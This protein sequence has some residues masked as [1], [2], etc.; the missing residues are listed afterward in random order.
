MPCEMH[1]HRAK[2]MLFECN[3]QRMSC[4]TPRNQR[5]PYLD[6]S[7]IVSGAWTSPAGQQLRQQLLTTAN[8]P[9]GQLIGLPPGLSLTTSSPSPVAARATGP[10]YAEGKIRWYTWLVI[11][12]VLLL[13]LILVAITVY[14]MR[15]FNRG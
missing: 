15:G 8:S 4:E 1:S 11:S 5:E 13:V 6:I 3:K 10:R 7:Q 9:S 14:R 12:A 2:I